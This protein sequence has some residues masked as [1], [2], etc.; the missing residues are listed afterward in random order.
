MTPQNIVKVDLKELSVIEVACSHCKGSV[1]IPLTSYRDFPRLLKC[2]GCNETWWNST[3]DQIFRDMAMM[4]Q[5]IDNLK[6]IESSRPPGSKPFTLQFP[7]QYSSVE[8]TS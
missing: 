1:S 3:E 7:L 6:R 4:A 5:S 2:P 8:K